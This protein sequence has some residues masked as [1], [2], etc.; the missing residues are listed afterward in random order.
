MR[1]D[2]PKDF[3]VKIKHKDLRSKLILPKIT[4]RVEAET[5]D[6]E[7]FNGSIIPMPKVLLYYLTRMELIVFS[8]IMEYTTDVSGCA[9]T[10]RELANKV[11]LSVNTVSSVL[12]TLR[13]SGLLLESNHWR[14]R[15]GRVLKINYKTVQHLNDLT[16]GIDVGIYVRIRQLARKTNIMSI[17]KKDIEQLYDAYTQPLDHDPAEEE[18]YD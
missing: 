8:T 18:E 10:V 3:N 11:R 14:S 16:G 15:E 7:V 5:E 1:F 4:Y 17:T 6:E 2:D 12:Y 13:K 9:M